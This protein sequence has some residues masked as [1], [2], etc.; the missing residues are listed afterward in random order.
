LT[1]TLTR[2]AGTPGTTIAQEA[3][4]QLGW[5]AYDHELLEI[6]AREKHL[7]ASQLEGLDE[8]VRSQLVTFAESIGGTPSVTEFGYFR[9]LAETILLLA[10][11]GRCVIVGR[12]AA[13]LLPKAKTLSVRVVGERSDRIQAAAKDRGLSVKEAERWVTETDEQRERFVQRHF[14]LD[15]T[16]PSHY[17]LVLNASHW[18]VADA[19]GLVVEAVRRR[20]GQ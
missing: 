3:A 19:A 2:E 11:K 15:A 17:D 18:T 4:R 7:R 9:D 6:V 5:Q 16:N 14:G 10:A 12:G 1:I 20:T 13:F 8:Q